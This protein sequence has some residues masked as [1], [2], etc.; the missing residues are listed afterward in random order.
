MNERRRFANKK[1]ATARQIRVTYQLRHYFRQYMVA[2]RVYMEQIRQAEDQPPKLFNPPTPGE[3][4]EAE[5]S[6]LPG[7]VR[8]GSLRSF[9]QLKA[10][11]GSQE[12]K[13]S[14]ILYGNRAECL[15]LQRNYSK[16]GGKTLR[17]F[18]SSTF[19]DMTGEREIFTRQYVGALRQ[20]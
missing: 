14:R 8:R 12:S 13:V 19:S 2:F 11:F 4:N 5:A 1:E 16:L 7:N 10:I 17:V 9:T 15:T 6:Y 3:V 18:L 20:M